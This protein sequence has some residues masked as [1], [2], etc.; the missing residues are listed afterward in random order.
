LPHPCKGAEWTLPL[1]A[2][3]SNAFTVVLLVMRGFR[4]GFFPAQTALHQLRTVLETIEKEVSPQ[5]GRQSDKQA[6]LPEAP[7]PAEKNTNKPERRE[8]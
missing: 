8:W 2:V 1:N 7:H 6:A 4:V 3:Y 5:R